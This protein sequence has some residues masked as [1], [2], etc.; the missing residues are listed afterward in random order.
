MRNE[1]GSALLMVTIL[2]VLMVLM[3]IGL[4]SFSMSTTMTGHKLDMHAIAR[5]AAET[6]IEDVKANLKHDSETASQSWFTTAKLAMTQPCEFKTVGRANVAISLFT[7]DAAQGRYRAEALA[8]LDGARYRMSMEFRYQVT[9]G[10]GPSS[11]FSKYA[12][13]VAQAGVNI[14]YVSTDG[15]YHSNDYIQFTDSGARFYKQVTAANR[16]VAGG[17]N[18]TDPYTLPAPWSNMFQSTESPSHDPSVGVITPPTYASIDADLRPIAMDPLQTPSAFWVD[19]ANVAEYPGML[20]SD[21]VKVT[22]S[23]NAATQQ[24]TATIEVVTSAG[25]PRHTRTQVVNP[26]SSTLIYTPNI[27]DNLKGTLYGRVCV[28]SAYKGTWQNGSVYNGNATLLPSSIV[29]RDDLVYVDQN[30][31]PK[32]WVYQGAGTASPVAQLSGKYSFPGI[33]YSTDANVTST[34]PSIWHVN[35][36]DAVW[37]N[38]TYGVRNNPNFNPAVQPCLGIIANGDIAFV[39]PNFNQMID[40]A[41]YVADNLARTK[42]ALNTTKGNLKIFGSRTTQQSPFN[43]SG[44]GGFTRSRNFIYDNDLL[45]SPPPFFVPIPGVPVGTTITVTYGSVSGSP[46]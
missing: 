31:N 34:N 14:G 43:V 26:N 29:I 35:N 1:R 32:T 11:M 40:G 9:G 12:T 13:F 2:G 30:G 36:M 22:F 38:S 21:K 7:V 41:L 15:Y 20:T 46:G 10:V 27:I 23:H 25:A 18:Y 44:S 28:C 17:I 45:S 5:Y 4:V 37:D 24:T 19:P 16:F 42:T 39:P 33:P 3:A 6:G 8:T